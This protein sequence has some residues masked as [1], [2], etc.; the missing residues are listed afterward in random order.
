MI[1]S[2]CTAITLAAPPDHVPAIASPTQRDTIT[3]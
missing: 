3:A 2:I 1:G